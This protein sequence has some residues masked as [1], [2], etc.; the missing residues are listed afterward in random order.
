MCEETGEICL[1]LHTSIFWICWTCRRRRNKQ[2]GSIPV[3]FY[4][5]IVL[6]INMPYR[7][8]KQSFLHT[9]NTTCTPFYLS[10]F[11]PDLSWLPLTYSALRSMI[12]F[13]VLLVWRWKPSKVETK[14]NRLKQR[15]ESYKRWSLV[16]VDI[17]VGTWI[18][19]TKM[20]QVNMFI[21]L[22]NTLGLALWSYLIWL[23]PRM[24]R[25][26]SDLSQYDSLEFNSTLIVLTH[27]SEKKLTSF[28]RCVDFVET[29][30]L[31]LTRSWYEKYNS[32]LQIR[33]HT[34]FCFVM[35]HW[36]DASD[37]QR[38]VISHTP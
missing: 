37:M 1:V 31:L 18:H 3:F 23:S 16:L 22:F 27:V 29:K 8:A 10:F 2:K 28:I 14:Q 21:Q 6:N 15:G 24:I 19:D 12:G 38:L 4:I 5:Y 36:D 26:S 32:K 35:Q 11:C 13:E 7:R 25:F 20:I 17:V 33:T 30:Q 9:F 34:A